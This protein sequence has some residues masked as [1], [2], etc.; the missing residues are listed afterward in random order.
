MGS[1]WYAGGGFD[2]SAHAKAI[3]LAWMGGRARREQAA[4]ADPAI[5]FWPRFDKAGPGGCWLWTGTRITDGYGSIS[6]RQKIWSTHRLAWTLVNGLIPVGLHV[7]HHCDVRACANPAHLFLGT[8][9][10]N[11]RDRVDKG[12]DFN[13][14]KTHC[15]HGHPF[16]DANTILRRGKGG[17]LERKCHLCE[18]ESSYRAYLVRGAKAALSGAAK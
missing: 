9:A 5:V 10:D 14:R 8:N 11:V 16:D 7:L 3:G 1:T 2:R 15:R 18:T 17:R 13:S 6:F 4:R 12:R